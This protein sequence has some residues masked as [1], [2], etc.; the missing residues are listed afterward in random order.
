VIAAQAQGA[1]VDIDYGQAMRYADYLV[2]PKGAPNK[3][4]AMKLIAFASQAPQ[5]AAMMKL[6]PNSSPNA[7]ALKLLDP[8]LAKRLP[9]APGNLEREVANNP[10]FYGEDSGNGQTWQQIGLKTW[11]EWY[12]R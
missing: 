12:G 9:T 5:S 1:K 8:E 7:D 6:Q 4:A 10:T 3:I 2:V 11:N